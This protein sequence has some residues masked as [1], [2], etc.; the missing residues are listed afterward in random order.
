[1]PHKPLEFK[2]KLLIMCFILYLKDGLCFDEKKFTSFFFLFVIVIDVWWQNYCARALNL[3]NFAIW[4][5]SQTCNALGNE[6]NWCVWKNTL[7]KMQQV[8]TST[9]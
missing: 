9:N 1:M 6:H 7:Q 5:L 4:A 8:I 3:Q 2:V